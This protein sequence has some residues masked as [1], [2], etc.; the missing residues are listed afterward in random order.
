LS[1]EFF[2]VGQKT[3]VTWTANSTAYPNVT[4]GIIVFDSDYR[5]ANNQTLQTLPNNGSAEW[6]A[7]DLDGIY[8]LGLSLDRDLLSNATL[9]NAIAVV[10]PDSQS[11]C[12]LTM[13]F[14]PDI[15]GIGVQTR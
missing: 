13:Q 14:N 2:V 12:I 15:L 6:T 3:V 9:S 1:R 10:P 11:L 7:P 5:F 4:L 8:R